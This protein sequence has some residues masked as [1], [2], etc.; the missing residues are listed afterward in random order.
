MGILLVLAVM[1]PLPSAARAQGSV[2]ESRCGVSVCAVSY[3][4]VEV[5]CEQTRADT[6]AC[7]GEITLRGEGGGTR[8]PLPVGLP[9][10]LLWDR[11]ESCRWLVY[12]GDGL[13]RS[14]GGETASE[15]ETWALGDA[16]GANF[17]RHTE[18]PIVTH[19]SAQPFCLV[20]HVDGY[21]FAEAR[22]SVLTVDVETVE[23]RTNWLSSDW[24]CASG[25]SF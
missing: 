3:T 12:G 7:T 8:E 9:G 21:S 10:R 25:G 1:S 2:I 11:S 23:A 14:C 22:T 6:V 4:M 24:A 17:F 5:T 15:L 20:M 16:F 18:F 13:E 19:T